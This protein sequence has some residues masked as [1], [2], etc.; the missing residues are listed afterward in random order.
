MK[1]NVQLFNAAVVGENDDDIAYIIENDRLHAVEP[2]IA[3]LKKNL[4][5]PELILPALRDALKALVKFSKGKVEAHLLEMAPTTSAKQNNERALLVSM[6]KHIFK[7]LPHH[8][9]ND[10]SSLIHHKQ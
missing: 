8:D 10:L 2:H 1:F 7:H 9:R 3:E 5:S 6:I 4:S